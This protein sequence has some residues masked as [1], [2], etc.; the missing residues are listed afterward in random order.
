MKY[1]PFSARKSLGWSQV[2]ENQSAIRTT[3]LRL[4]LE[5]RREVAPTQSHVLEEES[6]TQTFRNLRPN[7]LVYCFQHSDFITIRKFD[8]LQTVGP[9]LVREHGLIHF[10]KTQ[11]FEKLGL[12]GECKNLLRS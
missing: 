4:R 5:L 9:D 2:W 8:T 12:I 6:R 1:D 7:K 3:Q 10:F 11:P